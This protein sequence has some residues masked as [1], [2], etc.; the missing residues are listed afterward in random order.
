MTPG[1]RPPSFDP[2]DPLDAPA[3]AT[4]DLHG[5][6]A[7]AAEAA[8]KNFLTTWKS[9]SPGAVVHVITGKGRGSKTTPVLK[10]L[11]R[12]LLKESKP[13]IVADWALSDDEGGYR[14]RLS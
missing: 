10:P 8:L 7:D 11:V 14:V 13:R 6:S 4:L 3:A 1:P 5:F 2:R 12:R 9:R